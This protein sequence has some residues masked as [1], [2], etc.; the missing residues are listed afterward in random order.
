M[1]RFA[2]VLFL[3]ISWQGAQAQH[4]SGEVS[5]APSHIRALLVV[6]HPDDESEL[7][8]T[9]YRITHELSGAVNQVIISDGE[10]GFRHSY[11]AGRYYNA[12]LDQEAVGRALL[13]RI[14][15]KEARHA[16]RVLSIQHQWFLNER[17]DHFT[18]ASNRPVSDERNCA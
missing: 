13:P 9:V 5:S 14:R 16:A 2:L 10:G 7:A 17:D 1:R 11:L 6:A 4:N 8:G 3:V 15:R 12:D 18:F